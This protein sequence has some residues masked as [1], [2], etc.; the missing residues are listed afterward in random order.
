MR[1]ERT[2]LSTRAHL[3]G[4]RRSS[5]AFSRLPAGTEEQLRGR[6]DVERE[7][8][9]LAAEPGRRGL[10][11]DLADEQVRVGLVEALERRR[12]TGS[13]R[14]SA[15]S[16]CARRSSSAMIRARPRGSRGPWRGGPVAGRSCRRSCAV[17]D[18]AARRRAPACALSRRVRGRRSARAKAAR[19]RDVAVAGQRLELRRSRLEIDLLADDVH[20]ASLREDE[21]A[22]GRATRSSPQP[23]AAG[24]VAELGRRASRATRT[25]PAG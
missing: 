10:R 1:P 6:T 13:A 9:R 8:S 22:L 4:A 16:I 17:D 24:A 7:A 2:A 18:R 19:E 14:A 23:A 21:L 25:R 20:R 3:V 5:A 11:L 12:R 15:R